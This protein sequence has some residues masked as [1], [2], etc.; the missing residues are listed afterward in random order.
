MFM[1]A[2]NIRLFRTLRSTAQANIN[3]LIRTTLRRLTAARHSIRTRSLLHGS[4]LLGL[5]IT[6]I[7]RNNTFK[8]KMKL[9]LAYF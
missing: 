2:I 1:T 6:G 9:F 5:T 8:L 4:S 3:Y 7:M